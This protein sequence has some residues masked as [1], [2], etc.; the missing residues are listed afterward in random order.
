LVFIRP[1]A[2]RRKKVEQL[3]HDYSADS[4]NLSLGEREGFPHPDVDTQI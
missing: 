4:A 3:L 2:G 1:T